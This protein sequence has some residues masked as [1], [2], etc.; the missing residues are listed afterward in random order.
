[1]TI[2]QLQVLSPVG[3]LIISDTTGANYL[4]LNGVNGVGIDMSSATNGLTMNA[5]IALGASQAWNIVPGQ[6]LTLSGVNGINFGANVLTIGG[7]GVFRFAPTTTPTTVASS[8][9]G[10][11]LVIQRQHFDDEHN[12]G[13]GGF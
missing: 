6:T 4:T 1:M 3:T 12:S 2:G 9:A 11:G 13:F 5:G 10:A 7:G 8:S